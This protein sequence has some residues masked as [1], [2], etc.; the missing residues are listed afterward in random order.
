MGGRRHDQLRTGNCFLTAGDGSWSPWGEE[1]AREEWAPLQ[2]WIARG[3]ALIVITNDPSTLPKILLNELW[4]ADANGGFKV[5][6]AAPATVNGGVPDDSSHAKSRKESADEKDSSDEEEPEFGSSAVA[7]A[8]PTSTADLPGNQMLTV[9]ADG[10]RWSKPPNQAESARDVN[11]VMWIRKSIG[12]GSLYVLL[13]DFAW[14]N[15]GFDADGNAKALA[16][17]LRAKCTAESSALTSIVTATAGP[18]RLL[19]IYCG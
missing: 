3:D 18:N 9:R 4:P 5:G 15:S 16:A 10:P 2:N 17:L 8:P 13:D 12:K 1:L 6:S 14:T 11:G 19:F 7:A